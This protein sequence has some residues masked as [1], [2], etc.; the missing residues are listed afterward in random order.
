[1]KTQAIDDDRDPAGGAPGTPLRRTAVAAPLRLL[2][3]TTAAAVPS[4]EGT[5]GTGV[6]SDPIAV[7]AEQIARSRAAPVAAELREQPPGDAVSDRGA[8]PGPAAGAADATADGAHPV[9]S[10]QLAQRSVLVGQDVAMHV[11]MQVPGRLII[12]GLVRGDIEADD[13]VVRAGGRLEGRVTC[14]RAEICGAFI[15]GIFV[16]DRLVVRSGGRASGQIVYGNALQVEPGALLNGAFSASEA[17]LRKLG[18]QPER[19]RAVDEITSETALGSAGG[20]G[21]SSIFG[22]V[23]GVIGIA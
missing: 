2:E 18:V 6:E 3:R 9:P 12:D 7:V 4:A 21:G 14:R 1:M 8:T 22:R 17:G 10:R 5:A 13:I 19:P 23:L 11:A 15:G 16:R 20:N